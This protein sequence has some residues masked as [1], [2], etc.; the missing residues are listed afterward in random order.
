MLMLPT[1]THLHMDYWISADWTEGQVLNPKLSN[2]AA[3]GRR[4]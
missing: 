2:H 1:M 3:P 4:N